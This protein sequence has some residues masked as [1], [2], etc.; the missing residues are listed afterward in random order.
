MGNDR[1]GRRI[2]ISVVEYAYPHSNSAKENG[3]GQ[4]FPI[5]K[6]GDKQHKYVRV[7]N[8]VEAF[9]A[10]GFESRLFEEGTLMHA[11]SKYRLERIGKNLLGDLRERPKPS[12]NKSLNKV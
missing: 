6:S 9:V 10:Y 11:I 8:A 12:E 2:Q 1:G 3:V 4:E 7:T 5:F